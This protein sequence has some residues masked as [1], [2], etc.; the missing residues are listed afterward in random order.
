MEK[1]P[2]RRMPTLAAVGAYW[3]QN[4]YADVFPHLN[5][6][7]LAMP[8]PCCFHCG[9]FAPQPCRLDEGDEKSAKQNPWVSAGGWLER[10]HLAE[11]FSG[12]SD[13]A[14]NL[15]PLCNLCHRQMP[16]LIAS[17]DEAIAWVNSPCLDR[18]NQWWQ[19]AT[20]DRWG[21]DNH[22]RFPGRSA[23]YDFRLHVDAVVREHLA[24]A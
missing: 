19:I 10:A 20:D 1:L 17:R 8:E 7:I 22:A 15:V 24:A 6:Y 14:E 13:Q 16:Q 23:I 12:G 5:R 18:G 3:A 21:G 9:W 4:R 2:P 11:R